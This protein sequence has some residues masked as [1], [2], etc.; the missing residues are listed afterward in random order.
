MSGS[1]ALLDDGDLLR[2]ILCRNFDMPRIVNEVKNHL[3]WRQT[4]VPLPRLNDA[5]LNLLNKGILYLHG[6]CKDFTPIII[7]DM[8]KLREMLLNN[9][10]DAAKFC[11]L[12]NFM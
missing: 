12:N 3:E 6:R 11:S 7:I 10:L 9:E 8:I 2:Y 1:D 4:N 5:T